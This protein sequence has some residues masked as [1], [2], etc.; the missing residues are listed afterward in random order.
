MLVRV[1]RS[2]KLSSLGTYVV[3]GFILLDGRFPSGALELSVSWSRV[4]VFSD[5]FLFDVD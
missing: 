1:V 2:R 5:H 3:G 4:T